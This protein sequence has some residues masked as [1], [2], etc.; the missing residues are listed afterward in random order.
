[1][2]V[3]AQLAVAVLNADVKKRRE[4]NIH[5]EYPL[6]FECHRH[7]R[8]V[9]F[10]SHTFQGPLPFSRRKRGKRPRKVPCREKGMG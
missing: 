7:S 3:A 1:M 6:N 9:F 4:M 8:H 2:R 5:V 10:V